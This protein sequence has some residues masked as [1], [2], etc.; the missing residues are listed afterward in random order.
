MKILRL[1]PGLWVAAT[2]A[3]LLSATPAPAQQYQISTVAGSGPSNNAWYG[4]GLPATEAQLNFPLR[5]AFDNQG[6]YYIADFYNY[7][8]R[9]VANTGIINTF[10]GTGTAG[11]NG[12]NGPAVSVTT[13]V[14]GTVTTNV[15]SAEIGLVFGLATDASLNLYVADPNNRRVRR[16]TAGGLLTTFAGDGTAGITYQAVSGPATAAELNL[17]Y[18]LAVDSSNNVYISDIGLYTVFKVDGKTGLITTIAG[19]GSPGYSG[20]GGAATSAA[21]GVPYAIAFD[22]RGNLYISDILNQNIREITNGN[23]RTVVSG[24]SAVSIAIDAS[25]NIY[26]PNPLNSTVV[27]ILPGGTQVVIAGNGSAGYS[28]DG[29]PA[30]FAQLN[31]PN[32]VALDASGNIYVTDSK[33]NVV[34]ELTL[35]SGTPGLGALVNAASNQNNQAAPGE[36][37]VIYGYGIGP[38]TLTLNQPGS[39]GYYGTQ[40]GGTSVQINGTNA[41]M[42][43][44]SANQV[45]AIVPFEVIPNTTVPITLTYQG[46]Q[47][48]ASNLQI[49]PAAPAVF[50]VNGTGSGQA[51]AINQN[52]TLNSSSN[53]ATLGSYVS[54]YITGSGQTSPGGVDGQPAPAS[55]SSIPVPVLPV[56]VTVGGQPAVVSYAGGAPGLVS[57]LTQVNIQIPTSLASAQVTLNGVFFVPVVVQVGTASSPATATLAVTAQ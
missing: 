49:V 10:L 31:T 55:L 5:L 50:T 37:F 9:Q 34:R 41:P 35:V 8:V 1:V 48:A 15:S 28:G 47:T 7:V 54:L 33:N 39:N 30:G 17:P 2:L 26:Y 51:A 16:V 40:V 56:S 6:N 44:A 25:G 42:I 22:P 24:V 46:Q 21:I 45:A 18:G 32:G 38:S 14:N 29:G 20:D 52:G 19:T 11:Y 23:I 57:G 27:K 43:Y 3:A 53:P 12:D 36:I 13:T 4:D